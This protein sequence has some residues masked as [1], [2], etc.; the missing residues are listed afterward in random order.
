MAYR[1][2]ET[3]YQE[4]ALEDLEEEQLFYLPSFESFEEEDE[5][6]EQKDDEN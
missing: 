1:F 2:I 3:I 4:C 6:L 5:I